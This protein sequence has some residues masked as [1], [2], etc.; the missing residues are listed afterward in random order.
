[1]LR[2]GRHGRSLALLA[3]FTIWVLSPFVALAWA[4]MISKR[5]PA[6][7]RAK[8]S[9]VSLVVPLASLAIYADAALGPPRAKPA[10]T[11]LLVPAAS[12]LP[13]AIVVSIAGFRPRPRP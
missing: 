5:W 10:S 9:I 11:F 4:H 13:I 1:M 6:P 3:L 2:A 7:A 8:L 12:W